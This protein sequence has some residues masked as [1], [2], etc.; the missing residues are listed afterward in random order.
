MKIAER[1][2]NLRRK[3]LLLKV[4]EGFRRFRKVLDDVITDFDVITYVDVI[5]HFDVIIG[6]DVITDC[7]V[8]TEFDDIIAFI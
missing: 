1:P 2:Q 3:G 6:F 8:I 5:T 4:L 7:G